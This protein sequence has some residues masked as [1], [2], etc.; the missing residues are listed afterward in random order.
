MLA[1][2]QRRRHHHRHLLA[3]ERGDEG[4]AERDLGLAE[5]DIAANQPVHRPP[6]GE[7]GGHGVDRDV[8]IV[9]FLVGKA[10]AELVVETFRHGELRRLAELPRGGDAHELRR[11]LADAGLETRFP[12]LPAE[13]AEAVEFGRR[14][15]VAVAREQFE[16]FDRQEQ[17]VAAVIV[18]LQAIV[19]RAQRL[20]GFQSGEAA[21]AVIDMDDEIA[22]GETGELGDEI[23]GAALAA[24]R[25]RE[26]V[27][28]N[29]LL[30]NDRGVAALETGLEAEHGEAEGALRESAR[31]VEVRDRPKI[32]EPVVQQHVLHALAR[33]LAP[34]GEDHAFV[35]GLQCARV[36][37]DRVE[38]VAVFVGALGGEG[39]AGLAAGVDHVARRGHGEGRETDERRVR[40]PRFPFLFREVEP[41]WRQRLVG[42]ALPR[43]HRLAPR[44]VIVGDLREPLARRLFDQRLQHDRRARQ[45]VEEGF[46]LFCEQRQ[47]VFEAGMAAA[48]AHRLEKHIALGLAAELGDI[49]HAEALDRFLGELDFAGG[50]QCKLFDAAGRPLRF[51][52]EGADRFQRVAE[53]IEPHRRARPRGVEIENAAAHGVFADVAHGRG[54]DK[55]VGLE[56]T[57]DLVHRPYIAGRKR[58]RLRGDRRAKRHALQQRIDRGEHDAGIAVR[59]RKR[60]QRRHAGCCDRGVG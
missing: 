35:R 13:P 41:L 49:T 5:A 39:A 29:V 27:A 23:V 24:A 1:R 58:E 32:G 30:G 14:F 25:A 31:L 20:D 36:D 10:R 42:R 47:P 48:L 7:V 56:P 8:L 3:G 51:R 54:A 6:G 50:E 46:E 28:K 17:P 11:H 45:I 2:E 16:V 9:G 22:S 52:I 4:G 34:K 38:E 53:K 59:A 12:R 57:R 55:A 60:C 40:E 18:D 37:H 15:L 44:R 33:A 19:R 21:D 43:L 26:P